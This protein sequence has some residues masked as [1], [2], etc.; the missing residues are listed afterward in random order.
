MDNEFLTEY[1][2]DNERIKDG[3]KDGVLDFKTEVALRG[4]I[5]LCANKGNHKFDKL[6]Y[7]FELLMNIPKELYSCAVEISKEYFNETDV[8]KLSMHVVSRTPIYYLYYDKVLAD[9]NAMQIPKA[10]FKVEVTGR[11]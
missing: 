2:Y 6:V 1:V 3:F 9:L 11:K 10:T 4:D 7:L 5:A 8:N